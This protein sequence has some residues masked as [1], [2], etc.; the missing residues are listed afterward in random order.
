MNCGATENLEVD[1]IIPLC[2]GGKH[3]E[4][5]MQ[6][7]C[8]KCNCKKG[9]KPLIK[10]FDKYFKRGDGDN[11]VFISRKFPLKQMV[12]GLFDR[13][14]ERQFTKYCQLGD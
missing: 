1:H 3:D 7:L 11:Y 9:K 6:I 5:N 12:N 8:K 2:S 4:D 10:D 14:L 13:I